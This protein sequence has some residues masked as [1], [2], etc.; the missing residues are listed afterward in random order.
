MIKVLSAQS[1]KAIPGIS[2]ESQAGTNIMQTIEL[3]LPN[4]AYILSAAI[5]QEQ[6]M[7]A[8]TS[9]EGLMYF[10]LYSSNIQKFRVF[11]I[12]CACSLGGKQHK[13][14]YLPKHGSFF[15]TGSK[16]VLREWKIGTKKQPFDQNAT[17]I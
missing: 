7:L 6:G 3:H 2:H 10:Y 4:E 16:H 8:L 11:K 9:T 17:S 12:I 1:N 5:N 13:I 15:T 14:W